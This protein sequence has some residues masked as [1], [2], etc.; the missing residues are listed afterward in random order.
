MASKTR[1]L[2]PCLLKCCCCGFSVSPRCVHCKLK[3]WCGSTEQTGLLLPGANAMTK[4][5][6]TYF[7]LTLGWVWLIPFP[8]LPP[9]SSPFFPAPPPPSSMFSSLP[10]FS[11][12]I[13]YL[14]RTSPDLSRFDLLTFEFPISSRNGKRQIF[15]LLLACILRRYA[16]TELF[17][18][19]FS[20]R[21]REKEKYREKKIETETQ[22]HRENL[23]L[24]SLLP[25]R[26]FW[27]LNSGLAGRVL[28]LL[29]HLAGS[30]LFL[31]NAL[32]SCILLWRHE[33]DQTHFVL[34]I[35][36]DMSDPSSGCD[37]RRKFWP[38]DA[39]W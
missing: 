11:H 18:Y 2:L 39:L 23:L 1:Q 25:S 15:I 28:Y 12:G 38:H 8:S 17:M 16:C 29:N 35:R 34:K 27:E 13:K 3:L 14:A 10:A 33:T 7:L 4:D 32:V 20:V 19:L 9:S 36:V 21:V 26:G 31:I 37:I 22:S 30:N 6:V 24:S 5:W